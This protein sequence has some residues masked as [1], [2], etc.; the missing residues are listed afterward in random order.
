MGWDAWFTLGLV[1]A[2]VLALAMERIAPDVV[3]LGAV[4][5]LLLV[6]ILTPEQALAGM[7]N[8]GMITVGVM[9]IVVTGL[10]DTG[11]MEWIARGL[12]G[13][14]RTV[15][16]AQARLMTPVA[17]LSAFMNNTPL[18][19]MFIPPVSSWAK[20]NGLAP[21]KLM[22]PMS[23]AAILG[24]VCSLI[25]TSTNLVVH[26]LMLRGNMPGLSMFEIAWVGVPC[27]IAGVV[28]VVAFGRA[29]LPDRRPAISQLSDTRQYT[30]EMLVQP[31]SPL[32][33]QTI[34]AA[35]LRHL[36]SIFLAEIEREGEILPAVGPDEKLRGGDRLV[37]VGVPESVVD[38]QKI[39]GLEPATNQV[40]KLDSPRAD[41]CLI[42]VVVSNSGP[43]VGH[44]IREGRFRN[45]YNAVVI[46]VARDGE[47]I[48]GKIGDIV[49]RAGDTLL[50]EAHPEFVDQQRN[51]RDFLLVSPLADSAPLRYEKAPVA[52]AILIGLVVL[53]TLEW[54]SMLKAALLGAGLMLITRCCSARVAR[55]SV[56]WQ[57]L[58]VIAGSFALGTALEKTGASRFVA[59]NLIALAG[60][61][62][63]LTLAIVMGVTVAF[64]ELV[65]NNAAAVL[66]FPIALAASQDLGVDFRPFAIAI[67]MGASCGF[68][69]PIGYQT[70]LI[71][72]GPGGY[73]F[74]DFLRIGIPMDLLVWGLSIALIPVFWPLNRVSPHPH[75]PPPPPPRGPPTPP[76]PRRPWRPRPPTARRRPPPRGPSPRRTSPDFAPLAA[77]SRE[78]RR[79]CR[80]AA[81]P[82]C[83]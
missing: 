19:A 64:T 27:A 76:P 41:R 8:E 52:L 40:F 65:T 9:Y 34:E 2:V 37:F 18:V 47:R 83:S 13:R 79:P 69:S 74:T 12:L 14:P 71:V 72:Y 22:I 73:R 29:L 16:A 42:E 24:G 26:G 17:L 44:T 60:G 59:S 1:T 63:W 78:S 43:V 68:A 32:V 30:V 28:F 46:A 25:G 3:V 7:A 48:Q 11:G 75:P 10:R 80:G 31:G 33:G 81:G 58:L 67:L 5:L 56:D 77:R 82:V 23:Y 61:H 57:V 4:T 66:V 50:L 38:L 35:G 6:G 51:A 45:V 21:S 20:R 15:A 55:R 36:P 49:L 62:P 70:H 53:A 39:R 54:L